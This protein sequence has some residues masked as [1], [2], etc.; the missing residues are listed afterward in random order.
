MGHESWRRIIRKLLGDR[1]LLTALN[2]RGALL[3]CRFHVSSSALLS[4]ESS[5]TILCLPDDVLQVCLLSTQWA[6]AVN[7]LTLSIFSPS[8][9]S[10]HCYWWAG[11]QVS[12]ML[13][14]AISALCHCCQCP[15]TNHHCRTVV[16]TLLPTF[17]V[18]F[19]F[20]RP[21][22]VAHYP[23]SLDQIFSHR[24]HLSSKFEILTS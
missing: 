14:K 1:P 17:L 22:L 6:R 15:G 24:L 8:L 21:L 11:V 4:A 12:E 16:T 9:S 7:Q 5:K 3:P 2:Y 18:G 23:L 20:T 19:R 13:S 10:C